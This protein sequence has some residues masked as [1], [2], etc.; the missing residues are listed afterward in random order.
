MPEVVR[1]IDDMAGKVTNERDDA[2]KVFEEFAKFC[3]GE[4][5]ATL[6]ERFPATS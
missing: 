2:A 1:L 3:D 4:A 5:V 6:R